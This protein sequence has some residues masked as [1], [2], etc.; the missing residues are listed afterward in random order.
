MSRNRIQMLKEHWNPMLARYGVLQWMKSIGCL[1][2]IINRIGQNSGGYRK[3]MGIFS[4]FLLP[5][6][7][8]PDV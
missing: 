6:P 2:R 1:P 5:S 3:T 7:E 4:K 8:K